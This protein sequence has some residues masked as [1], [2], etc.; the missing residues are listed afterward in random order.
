IDRPMV[1]DMQYGLKKYRKITAVGNRELVTAVVNREL[2]GFPR[3]L[4][5][6]NWDQ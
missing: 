6:T 5:S 2:V 4:A 1:A 3:T